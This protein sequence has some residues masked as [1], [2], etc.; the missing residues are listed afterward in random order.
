M[1]AWVWL[2]LTFFFVNFLTMSWLSPD[3]PARKSVTEKPDPR[4]DALLSGL[5]RLIYAGS[6]LTDDGVTTHLAALEPFWPDERIRAAVMVHGWAQS[7]AIKTHKESAPD[8]AIWAAI[9]EYRASRYE[10]ASAQFEALVAAYPG[11]AD[12][13]NNYGLSLIMLGKMTEAELHL[14]A[15]R[16]AFPDH[17]PGFLNLAL[18]YLIADQR[19]AFDELWKTF[20]VSKSSSLMDRSLL[21]GD[22]IQSSS[23]DF[24]KMASLLKEA[25]TKYPENR[26]KTSTMSEPERFKMWH[27]YV[28]HYRDTGYH[29]AEVA[30]YSIAWQR[31]MGEVVE[32]FRELETD[33]SA[34]V[35]DIETARARARRWGEYVESYGVTEY[36]KAEAE[37]YRKKWSAWPSMENAM[38][39]FQ[40]YEALES[41]LVKDKETAIAR[42]R[43]WKAYVETYRAT[44]HKITEAEAYQKKWVFWPPPEPGKNSTFNLDEGITLDMVWIPGGTFQ[45]GSPPSES[46]RDSD[47]GP[48]HEVDLD[49]FWMGKTE[50]TQEQYQAIMGSNPSNFEGAKNPVEQVSWDEAMEFC[51]KISESTGQSFTLPTEAQWEYACRAGTTTPFHFGNTISA[52][53]ANYDGNYSY[54]NGEKGEYRESTVPAG[55]FAPNAFGL[56]DMHGNVWEWCVDWY[57]NY[58]SGRQKNPTGPST[59]SYRVFRGGGWFYYPGNCRSAYRSRCTPGIQFNNL[60]FFLALQSEKIKN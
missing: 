4:T 13:R 17:A 40:E 33:D 53:Q 35:N 30:P 27:G 26:K 2:S 23:E 24:I 52:S 6:F 36:K 48:V 41:A 60:G 16:F 12:A 11:D 18:V 32:K 8:E 7:R 45:M 15:V 14:E 21:Y 57:G 1:I 20:S 58:T 19:L 39:R 55:S 44:G 34:P 25:M 46:G 43:K 51:R 59:G 49:G 5:T 10:S 29:I 3:R 37:G 56:Y 42:A 38:I 50:V 28:E 47:E 22:A 54:G 31:I 9:K